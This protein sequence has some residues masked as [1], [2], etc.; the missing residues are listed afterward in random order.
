MKKLLQ[1]LAFSALVLTTLAACTHENIRPRDTT[2]ADKCQFGGK[3][4]N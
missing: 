3:S 2:T 1:T 4:C